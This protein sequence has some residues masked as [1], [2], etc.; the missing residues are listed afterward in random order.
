MADFDIPF[1]VIVLGGGL[2]GCSLACALEGKGLRVALVEARAPTPMPPG[3]DE[4]R[5]AL[6]AATINALSSLGVLGK[7]A[8]PPSALRRIHVS[9]SGDFGSVRLDADEYGRDA[10]GGVVS[11]REL[12]LALEARLA[13]LADTR[14]LRPCTVRAISQ[15]AD[16]CSIDA[17]YDGARVQL[18][19][20]LLVAADGTHSFARQQ[21]GIGDERHD[22]G[23][24][25]FVS[26]LSTDR[27]ADGTAYER[28]T[29][30]GPTALLPM[31]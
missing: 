15:D 16:A 13:G 20:A 6:A 14:V 10:F 11:A 18:R 1:D 7:L 27:A 4:R 22:Y 29:E 19:T 2:V 3:F 24:T 21:L 26:A 25:L 17:E 12:G 5:L 23:Q 9:R 8:A 28:F 31:G 30:Q